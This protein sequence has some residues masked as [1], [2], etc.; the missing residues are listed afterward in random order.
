M[1]AQGSEFVVSLET[2]LRQALEKGDIRDSAFRRRVYVAAATAL[3]RS[4]E[5][6]R[7]VSP[8]RLRRQTE[9]LTAI[10]EAIEREVQ[11]VEAELA[12]EQA[13]RAQPPP[14]ARMGPPARHVAAPPQGRG[15]AREPAHRGGMHIPPAPPLDDYEVQ[16]LHVEPRINAFSEPD[17]IAHADP[18][19]AGA[20]ADDGARARRAQGR[21]GRRGPAALAG[22]LVP[23]RWPF[24][25]ARGPFAAL[26]AGVVLIGLLFAGV[27]WVI[28]S[29]AFTSRQA[30]DTSVPNPPP[31]LREDNFVGSSAAPANGTVTVQPPTFTPDGWIVLFTPSDPTTLAVSGGATASI[32]S[33]PFGAYARLLTPTVDS[34]VRIDVPVGTL[35][36]LAGGQA[37]IS[38]RART[39]GSGASQMAITCDFGMLGDCG[40]RRFSL[41]QS[42]TEYLFRF[43][44]S[45]GMVPQSPG[46]VEITTGTGDLAGPI[47]LSVARIRGAP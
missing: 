15:P 3:Q 46:A 21:A 4:A 40:R 1:R 33:D 38:F 17:D 7:R 30:R 34:S 18:Q 9:R 5:A 37:E 12:A 42:E 31:Q 25:L 28:T 43:D 16:G 22:R 36:R 6:H 24:R 10:I 11:A 29:G 14:T 2:A 45:G 41:S 27:I 35:Q 13:R 8:D 23:R 26:L 44:L 32:Q 47:R 19:A 39:D 20:Y